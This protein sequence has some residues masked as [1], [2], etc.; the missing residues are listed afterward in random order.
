MST[1]IQVQESYLGAIDNCKKGLGTFFSHTQS[2]YAELEHQH[3]VHTSWSGLHQMAG[4]VNATFALPGN[5]NQAWSNSNI[6][7]P[8]LHDTQSRSP[9]RFSDA[10]PAVLQRNR[11]Q[12]QQT[13][14][15]W[16][17]TSHALLMIVR[18]PEV[19]HF[20]SFEYFLTANVLNTNC[21]RLCNNMGLTLARFLSTV[22]DNS[23]KKEKKWL[24]KLPW[25]CSPFQW[26][27]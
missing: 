19:G 9:C 8:L 15:R 17:L 2:R 21:N 13:T 4:K 16:S 20:H 22:N 23:S 3:P 25:L 14:G 5:Q 7:H 11:E 18:I 27:H 12:R 26:C 6:W 24:P 1:W 10:T